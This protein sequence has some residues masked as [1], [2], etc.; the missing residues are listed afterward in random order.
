MK[1]FKLV[2]ERARYLLHL[3]QA[4]A[5]LADPTQRCC[6][7]I[8]FLPFCSGFLRG[9]EILLIKGRKATGFTSYLFANIST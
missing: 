8:V 9:E 4:A 7:I 3:N 6:N 5:K 1:I 2:G